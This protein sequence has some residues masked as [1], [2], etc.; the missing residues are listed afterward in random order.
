MA[1]RRSSWRSR[2]RYT[3]ADPPRPIS[4]CTDEA[5]AESASSRASQHPSRHTAPPRKSRSRP[6][7][8]R[9]STSYPILVEARHGARSI[10]PRRVAITRLSL[11]ARLN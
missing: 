1:T 10:A 9:M 6:Y 5:V 8:S 4:S 2:A 11:R 7:W 3:V